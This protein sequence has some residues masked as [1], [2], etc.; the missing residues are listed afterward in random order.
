MAFHASELDLSVERLIAGIRRAL[1]QGQH[2]S[3]TY[4]R[5]SVDVSTYGDTYRT[6]IPGRTRVSLEFDWIDEPDAPA[7]PVIGPT[8]A[9]KLPPRSS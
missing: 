6:Y 9:I 7:P 3:A 8:R 4:V 5:E 1:A 2:L